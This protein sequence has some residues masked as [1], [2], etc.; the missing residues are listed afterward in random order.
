MF[1]FAMGIE[2]V[3]SLYLV[4]NDEKEKHSLFFFFFYPLSKYCQFNTQVYEIISFGFQNPPPLLHQ[5]KRKEDIVLFNFAVT[6]H[7][8]WALKMA[9]LFLFFFR[10]VEKLSLKFINFLWIYFLFT[11]KQII[12]NVFKDQKQITITINN[13]QKIYLYCKCDMCWCIFKYNSIYRY[14]YMIRI[15][16]HIVGH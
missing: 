5:T 10:S 9:T 12:Q 2:I 3:L 4:W 1:P 6:F 11:N 16:D 14:I 13:K 15:N 7:L 8:T